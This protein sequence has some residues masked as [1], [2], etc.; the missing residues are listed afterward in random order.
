MKKKFKEILPGVVVSLVISSV[1][2]L[3]V[4]SSTFSTL[5]ANV[6]YNTEQIKGKVSKEQFEAILR[7]QEKMGE[8]VDKRLGK[9][10]DKLD[11][12]IERRK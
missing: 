10:E 1:T 6:M 8:T 4:F 11:R 12:I 2:S 5:Q 9:I 3:I 7:G